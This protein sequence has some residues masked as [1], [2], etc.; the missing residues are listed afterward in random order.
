MVIKDSSKLDLTLELYGLAGWL[1]FCAIFGTVMAI[2]HTIK[3]KK[4]RTLN[5]EE[6]EMVDPQHFKL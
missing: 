3:M 2:Y 5:E 4:Y 6:V 1:G